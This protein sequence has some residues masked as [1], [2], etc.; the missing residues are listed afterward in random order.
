[1]GCTCKDVITRNTRVKFYN[2]PRGIRKLSE[3]APLWHFAVHKMPGLSAG[4]LQ[5]QNAMGGLLLAKLCCSK[6]PHSLQNEF[7]NCFQRSQKYQFAGFTSYGEYQPEMLDHLTLSLTNQ[8]TTIIDGQCW[9]LRNGNLVVELRMCIPDGGKPN[10]A[11]TELFAHPTELQISVC[12]RR[13]MS[14][15]N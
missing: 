7:Q 6:L 4:I 13:H 9:H 12:F 8:A 2:V 10:L 1:M 15:D 3:A 14:G 5:P 11:V